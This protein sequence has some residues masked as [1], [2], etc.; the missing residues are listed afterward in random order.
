MIIT[1]FYLVHSVKL[2][3]PLLTF[4][5]VLVKEAFLTATDSFI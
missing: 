3:V 1:K 5:I 4:L 2:P